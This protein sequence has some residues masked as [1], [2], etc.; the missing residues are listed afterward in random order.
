[1]MLTVC[2]SEAVKKNVGGGYIGDVSNN[3]GKVDQSPRRL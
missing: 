1:M 3:V 2:E